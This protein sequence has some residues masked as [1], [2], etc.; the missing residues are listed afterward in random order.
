[1]NRLASEFHRPGKISEVGNK[2]RNLQ[3]AL[4]VTVL[5]FA[6]NVFR[7]TDDWKG[8]HGIL[9][10]LVNRSLSDRFPTGCLPTMIGSTAVRIFE[11]RK[12]F[13]IPLRPCKNAWRLLR[14]GVSRRH[15]SFRYSSLTRDKPLLFCLF[16]GDDSVRFFFGEGVLSQTPSEV[17]IKLI[18][19]DSLKRRQICNADPNVDFTFALIDAKLLETTPICAQ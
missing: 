17:F 9:N 19:L 14:V 4:A 6:S 1:M 3:G 2:D 15:T 12:T 16:Q 8:V 11:D 18:C 10:Q 7:W 13:H 5:I